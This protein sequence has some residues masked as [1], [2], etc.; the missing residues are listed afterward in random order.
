MKQDQK[1]HF[2]RIFSNQG[3]QAVVEYILLL[4]IIV[5]LVMGAKKAFGNVDDFISHYI[6]DYVTCLMEYGEL[7]S[8][9]VTDADQKKHLAGG[10]KKCDE[11]FAGFSFEDGRP[12]I[13]Y[14]SKGGGGSGGSG[15]GSGNKNNSSVSGSKNSSSSAK[16]RGN[17]NS[18]DSDS[19]SGEL[20]GGK[21]RGSGSGKRSEPYAKGVV[22]RSGGN[23]TSDGFDNSSQ[24]VRVLEEDPE[25][26]RKKNSGRFAFSR[27]RGGYGN[28]KYRAITG[29]MQAEIEKTLPK[30]PRTP[31]S[32]VVSL[33][34]DDA[35]RFGPYSK[36][37]IPPAP[38][39]IEIKEA[40]SSNFSFG[41]FIRWLII[42]AMI[43]A[44][45]IFFGGQIM[46][47]TN[48]KD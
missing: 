44:I 16:N 41:Y 22:Q 40:D 42:G 23:S 34:T 33:K 15:G 8:L 27:G 26:K 3:G 31:T 36:V 39:K 1:P 20:G 43:L 14:Q 37:F 2:R 38:A 17:R 11:A 7:P 45:I 18:S 13:T 9:G 21:N 28:N 48:S 29:Q 19:N 35:S 6:G 5:S 10:G 24:K 47:Y 12:S 30:K 4:V 25:L 32:T 46:N